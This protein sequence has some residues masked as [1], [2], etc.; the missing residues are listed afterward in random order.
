MAQHARRAQCAG[1]PSGPAPI[2][3]SLEI[4]TMH[5]I[6]RGLAG[7]IKATVLAESFLPV[8]PD[9]VFDVFFAVTSL[10]M[11]TV[12]AKQLGIGRTPE[13]AITFAAAF[14]S[15]PM[16][17]SMGP[18][19]AG[20]QGL[21]VDASLIAAAAS[22]AELGPQFENLLDRYIQEVD[23]YVEQLKQPLLAYELPLEM[24]QEFVHMTASRLDLPVSGTPVMADTPA[25]HKM[26]G[27]ARRLMQVR[28]SAYAWLQEAE[29]AIRA[30]DMRSAYKSASKALSLAEQENDDM[31]GAVACYNLAFAILAGGQ[32]PTFKRQD[33]ARLLEQGRAYDKVLNK[34]GFKKYVH[35]RSSISPD[36]I[37]ETFKKRYADVPAN[38]TCTAGMVY[39]CSRPCQSLHW[40]KHKADCRAAQEKSNTKANA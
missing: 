36:F 25:F 3:L 27:H 40:K 20:R 30:K 12:M 15:A 39:Y 6:L 32:G 5:T 7:F 10:L 37:R 34:Y 17:M 16:M 4:Q 21:D 29:F 11:P 13:A 28:P 9:F 26:W 14:R 31:F 38:K 18:V 35:S 24:L 23:S 33:V 19:L 8:D 1:Q 2:T 22:A